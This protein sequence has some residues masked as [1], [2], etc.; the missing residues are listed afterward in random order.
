MGVVALTLLFFANIYVTRSES[1]VSH[2][3]WIEKPTK[4]IKSCLS[5][6]LEHEEQLACRFFAAVIDAG[7]TGS[8]LHLFEFSHDPTVEH[9]PF[10]LESETFRQSNPGLSSYAADPSK[11]AESIKHLIDQARPKIPKELWSHTPIV[12]KATAGLRLLPAD[13]S[14]RILYEVEA[15]VLRSGLLTEDESV[16]ILSGIDE[17]VF[18]WFTLNFLTDRLQHLQGNVEKSAVA[19]DLGGGSTQVTFAPTNPSVA[20]TADAPED[21]FGHQ[22][23]VFGKKIRLYT[24]SYLGNG[25]IAARLGMSRLKSKEEESDLSV[26]CFP[27]GYVLKNWEYSG[28]NWTLCGTS[29]RSFQSCQNL[30]DQYV[31]KTNVRPV[32]NLIKNRD[33][34]VFAYFFDRAEQAGLTSGADQKGQWI[35]VGDYKKAAEKFCKMDQNEWGKEHW[36]PFQCMDLSYIYSLL[37]TGYGLT[38]ETKIHVS[39]KIKSMEVSWALGAGFH[40]LNT[41]HEN[42]KQPHASY[43]TLKTDNSTQNETYVQR[44]Y[45]YLSEKATELLVVLRLIS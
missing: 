40:L 10:K 2:V 1:H 28:R 44:V 24:H 9:S 41:Y 11:A 6:D 34:Y 42:S 37:T 33:I 31:K 3:E 26:D 4:E 5:P 43:A 8:R 30:A 17:G 14:D 27:N 38:D 36:R 32:A 15:E 39:K 45:T 20:F 35:K 18:G 22:L 25:L 23:E 21:D 19:L 29:R 16:G 12:V 13:E 7:S